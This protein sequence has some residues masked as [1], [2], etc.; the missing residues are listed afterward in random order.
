M[1]RYF[2]PLGNPPELDKADIEKAK[3][4]YKRL[5]NLDTKDKEKLQIAIDRWVE[6]KTERSYLDKIIDL[7]IAFES[8][9]VSD[10]SGEITFKFSVRAAWHLGKNKEHR[11]ELLTKFKQIYNCRSKAV[12]SGDLDP[13]VKF[14]EERIPISEFI[15][16]AQ[17]LCRESIIKIMKKGRFPNW[18]SLILD[19]EA[20][21]DAVGLDGNPGGSG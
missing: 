10:S 17:D 16:K 4:L 15:E 18:D 9:Y 13:T 20:E 2:E 3:C 6:S 19:G 14:G 5:I 12:H 11:N 8:L 7:G 1:F 21:N